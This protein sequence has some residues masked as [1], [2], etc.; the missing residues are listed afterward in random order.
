M[1]ARVFSALFLAATL[2]G[3]GTTGAQEAQSVAAF[4]DWTV[5]TPSNPRECF[6]VSPPVKTRA[7]RSGQTV[8]VRRG[9]VRLFVTTRPDSSVAQEVSYTSGYPFRPNSTVAVTIGSDSFTMHVGS[10]DGAEWAWPAS[11]E[12]DGRLVAAMRSGAEAQVSGISARGTTTYDTF[13]L[14][15]FTAAL[16]KAAELCK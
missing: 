4:K 11:P 8:S 16:D 7:E 3:A 9:D 15:G 6:I 5:F 1:S 13:S 2:A 10:G 12:D 14:N